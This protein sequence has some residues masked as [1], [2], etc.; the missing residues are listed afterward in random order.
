MKHPNA[1]GLYDMHGNVWELKSS[2]APVIIPFSITG[3][4]IPI[5]FAAIETKV[6]LD[7]VAGFQCPSI[8]FA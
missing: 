8:L 1:W 3:I 6:P 5:S 4:L 7:V 2:K